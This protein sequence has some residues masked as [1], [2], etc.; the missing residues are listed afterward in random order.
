[1]SRFLCTADLHGE[2]RAYG[3]L[4]DLCCG[5]GIVV[6]TLIVGGPRVASPDHDLRGGRTARREIGEPAS[7]GSISHTRPNPSPGPVIGDPF[8]GLSRMIRHGHA[9]TKQ[10]PSELGHARCE[11]GAV[12]D[13]Q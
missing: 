12:P 8:A 2:L 11:S 7:C 13:D 3:R 6:S 1:M 10:W 4:P 9:D 5:R